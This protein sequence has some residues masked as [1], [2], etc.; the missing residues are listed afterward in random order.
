MTI[1]PEQARELRD[2]IRNT[3][4]RA[5]KSDFKIDPT[6]IVRDAED[7]TIGAA[8]GGHVDPD[9]THGQADLIAAAPGMAETI[10]GMEWEW[11]VQHQEGETWHYVHSWR[12]SL[13]E[14]EWDLRKNKGW[15]PDSTFRIVRRLVS[16]P[17]VVDGE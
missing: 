2:G 4:W 10:A 6:G 12:K 16:S 1:T 8:E 3:P 7:E 14:A 17:E 5:I 13:S 11:A 15:S 9:F